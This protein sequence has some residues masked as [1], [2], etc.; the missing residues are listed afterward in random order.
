MSPTALLRD[1]REITKPEALADKNLLIILLEW[2]VESS[3]R[4][5]RRCDSD[6]IGRPSIRLFIGV[7]N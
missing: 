2:Y 4:E 6:L 5:L 3:D 1:N 7:W